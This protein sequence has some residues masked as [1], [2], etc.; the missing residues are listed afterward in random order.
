MNDK[1]YL[2]SIVSSVLGTAIEKPVS[3]AIGRVKGGTGDISGRVYL[4]PNQYEKILLTS[5]SK[6]PLNQLNPLPPMEENK[7]SKLTFE[8]IFPTELP[9]KGKYYAILGSEKRT[10]TSVMLLMN[11]EGY[12]QMIYPGQGRNDEKLMCYTK[13]EGSVISVRHYINEAPLPLDGGRYEVTIMCRRGGQRTFEYL[14]H[15]DVFGDKCIPWPKPIWDL[16][17]RNSYPYEDILD[18]PMDDGW[19]NFPEL[20]DES[21]KMRDAYTTRTQANDWAEMSHDNTK[22]WR[23][24]LTV[25][26]DTDEGKT[27]YGFDY[28]WDSDS[29]ELGKIYSATTP[30]GYYLTALY[31]IG[32]DPTKLYIESKEAWD[33]KKNLFTLNIEPDDKR[34]IFARDPDVSEGYQLRDFGHYANLHNHVGDMLGIAIHNKYFAV[35]ES[36]KPVYFWQRENKGLVCAPNGDG[37]PEQRNMPSFYKRYGSWMT[38]DV[39]VPTIPPKP[40]KTLVILGVKGQGLSSMPLGIREKDGRYEWDFRNQHVNSAAHENFTMTVDGVPKAHGDE[41][42]ISQKGTF[43]KLRLEPVRD[44]GYFMYFGRDLANYSKFDDYLDPIINIARGDD[45]RGTFQFC[46]MK[47]GFTNAPYSPDLT[48]NG[49]DIYYKNVERNDFAPMLDGGT[50]DEANAGKA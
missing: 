27:Y 5:H 7:L 30:E 41:V 21:G 33:D 8:T 28:G 14:L 34:L 26:R 32:D 24:W 39:C 29:K 35:P 1:Q 37:H 23:N 36:D 19:A 13:Q 16:R 18:L 12:A 4:W 22:R 46:T 10:D 9:P 42:D 17:I 44:R 43:L 6:H 45:V 31:Q 38:L 25:G 15:D 47:D 50:K 20:E 48:G 49:W 3:S 2:R 11:D 40:G